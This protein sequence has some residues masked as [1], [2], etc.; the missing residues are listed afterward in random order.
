MDLQ[1][2]FLFR[3]VKLSRNLSKVKVN[4]LKPF[5]QHLRSAISPY[6]RSSFDFLIRDR[7]TI[8]TVFCPILTGADE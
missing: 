3:K 2:Q 8:V 7:N 6:C 4:L 5:H 1:K